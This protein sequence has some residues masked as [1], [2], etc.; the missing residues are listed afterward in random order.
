[1]SRSGNTFDAIVIGAGHNGLVAAA[2]LARAGRRVLVLEARDA[3]GG[4]SATSE[5]VPGYAAPAV[6]HL[7]D[8]F[9]KRIERALKL[10]KH[11]L[12]YAARDIPT[13]ALDPDGGHVLL[14]RNRREF[15]RFA[16]RLPRDAEAY[17]DYAAD[18]HTQAALIAPLLGDIPPDLREPE[19]LRKFCRRLVWRGEISG[20]STLQKLMR[21][22]PESIGDRL[23]AEFE[24]PLLKGA[25]AFD[26][27][28]GGGEGPYAPG[29]SFRAV[30]REALRMQGQGLRQI[31]GGPGALIRALIA[32]VSAGGGELRL[33]AAVERIFIENGVAAGV[34]LLDGTLLRAPLVLSAINPR[35]TLLELAGAQCVE[36]HQALELSRAPRPGT[37]AKLNLALER[38]PLFTGLAAELHGARLLIAPSLQ[39]V[40]EAAAACNEGRLTSAP[41]LE[42]HMPSVADPALAPEGHQILSVIVHSAPHEVE[43][44]WPM[45]REG[46][47]QKVVRRIASF[48]PGIEEAMIAGEILTPP[49]IELKYGLAGGDWHQGDLRLD[50]LLAFRPAPGFSRYET[51]LAGLYLC[52]AGNHPGGGVTG[53]PGWIAAG[54]AIDKMEAGR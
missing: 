48:A 46:F 8:A 15:S 34:E 51:P 23:D 30:W 41:V 3:P 45:R 4:A 5:I 39:E 24:S 21:R 27:T 16:K 53:L 19:V 17:R 35:V 43:G 28:L 25:L 52:G 9:P 47:V 11:G 40:D 22:L 42:L 1:M 29:T 10:A 26:A 2:R 12:R 6:A 32:I 13:V 38:A 37:T 7:V 20:G 31:A 14:P 50:R 33:N 54:A 36:T 44:G 18:L 49:D